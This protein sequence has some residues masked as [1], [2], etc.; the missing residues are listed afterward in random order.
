[1]EMFRE[2]DTGTINREQYGDFGLLKFHV[3]RQL[4]WVGFL[5]AVYENKICEKFL[6]T[7]ERH[8]APG[9]SGQA[10]IGIWKN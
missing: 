1:M 10:Q 8:S 3:L 6:P 2:K 7:G 4:G 9:A 5:D